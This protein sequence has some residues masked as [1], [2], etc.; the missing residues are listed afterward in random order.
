M[1]THHHIARSFLAVGTLGLAA[2]TGC[3]DNND[4]AEKV[5]TRTLP[6]TSRP[7]SSP[8]TGPDIT[9]QAARQLC[10]MIGTEIDNWRDQGTVIAKVSFNGTVQDW[11]IRNDGLNDDVIRDKT[12]IDR[13]TVQTCPD[14]RQRALDV[15]DTDNLADALIGFGG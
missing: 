6:T 14:V 5:V 10:D 3:S 15:L 13:V 8:S 11:A 2:L 9:P 4:N 7:T 12:I 1:S